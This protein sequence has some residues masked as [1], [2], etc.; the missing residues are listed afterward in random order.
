MSNR[1]EVKVEGNATGFKHTMDT[2]RTQAKGAADAIS[3]SWSHGVLESF[4]AGIA[5]V[6]SFEGVKSSLEHF[7]ARASSLRDIS[8][9]L[10]ITTDQTQKWEKAVK[11]LGLSFGQ[12]QSVFFAIQGKRQEALRDPKAADLFSVLGITREQ[13]LHEDNSD[14]AARVLLAGGS[15]DDNRAILEQIVGRRGLKYAPA[16]KDYG[17]Q[18]PDISPDSMRQAKETE[19]FK[20]KVE[21]EADH[22]WSDVFGLLQFGYRLFKWSRK[23]WQKDAMLHGEKLGKFADP[24]LLREQAEKDANAKAATEAAKADIN[25]S[26]LE[27]EDPLEGIKNQ[28]LAEYQLRKEEAELALHE[29]QRRTIT[30][31]ARKK[32]IK[33][34]LAVMNKE[35]TER[36]QAQKEGRVFGMTKEQ[37]KNLLPTEIQKLMQTD[38]ISLLGL[39]ARASG[40]TS[41][42][43]ENKGFHFDADSLARVGL[44]SSSTLSINPMLQ[45]SQKQLQATYAVER[46]IRETARVD[47]HRR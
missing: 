3:H 43:R 46:A 37:Q 28:Q 40:F 16:A 30:I 31:A 29:S 36:E 34:D 22:M 13:V 20:E 19:D 1:L 21:N 7:L 45:L 33:A 47:P 26:A 41:E 42:L 11:Q 32:S 27:P 35:I 8:E 2:V 23:D 17:K 12:F 25:K 38:E 9:Q 24:E 44:F 4:G 15:G 18:T 5:G 39:R 10:E 14:F 6:L